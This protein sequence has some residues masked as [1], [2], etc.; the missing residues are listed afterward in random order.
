MGEVEAEREELPELLE[1][2][3]LKDVFITTPL[4]RMAGIHWRKWRKKWIVEDGNT[5]EFRIIQNQVFKP[6]DWMSQ[7]LKQVKA[8][9]SSTEWGTLGPFVF[10]FRGYFIRGR[11]DFE[12]AI[13]IP[14][15]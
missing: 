14:G 10:R 5:L 7:G 2:S 1:F 13:L 3:D 8:I 9:E 12:D 15:L 6:M 4:P 11:L